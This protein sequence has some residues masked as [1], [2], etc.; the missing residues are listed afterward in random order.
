MNSASQ[1]IKHLCPNNQI[2]SLN[3][4]CLTYR[5]AF[6]IV[7]FVQLMH[8]QEGLLEVP[9]LGLSC[10]Q[11]LLSYLLHFQGKCCVTCDLLGGF[12]IEVDLSAMS[13]M[14]D[15]SFEGIDFPLNLRLSWPLS[16]IPS[17]E[18]VVGD[19]WSILLHSSISGIFQHLKLK[20]DNLSLNILVCNSTTIIMDS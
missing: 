20:N 3:G 2:E 15:I 9:L 5:C 16:E 4:L 6:P 7:S 13:T 18:F 12:C 11:W 8:Q 10:P 14:I 19:L 17:T 1:Y